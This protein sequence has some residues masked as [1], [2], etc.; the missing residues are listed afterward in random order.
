VSRELEGEHRHP[1]LQHAVAKTAFCIIHDKTEHPA[2]TTTTQLVNRWDLQVCAH[3]YSTAPWGSA[4]T[5]HGSFLHRRATGRRR[6]SDERSS[7]LPAEPSR[8]LG[9]LTGDLSEPP[10]DAAPPLPPPLRGECGCWSL[11]AG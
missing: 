5:S 7:P 11:E 10:R 2:Q 6:I 3:D 1:R 9:D 8:G 4:P